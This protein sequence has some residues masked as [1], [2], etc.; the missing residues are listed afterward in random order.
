MKHLLLALIAAFLFSSAYGQDNERL[1]RITENEEID[2]FAKI[3]QIHQLLESQKK[4]VH[5]TIIVEYY[6]TLAQYAA[7]EQDFASALEYCDT[8]LKSYKN[9]DFALQIAVSERKASIYN[10]TGK[11]DRV[12]K[13]YM[14]I[15]SEQEKRKDY[16]EAAAVNGK[17]GV[18]FLKMDELES[19]EL[20]LKE[21]LRLAKQIG[22]KAMTATYLMSLGNRFKNEGKLDEAEKYYKECEKIAKE[23]NYKQTLAGNYN[24]Y[25]SLFRMRKQYA[26]AIKYFELAIKLN[27]ELG[28]DSW[29]SYNYNNIGNVY[30][31]QGLH[32]KALSYFFKSSDLKKS[33]ND[34]Y[35][36]YS[37]Y[38]NIASEYENLKDYQQA[39]KYFIQPLKIL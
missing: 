30:S 33:L 11:K 13:I 32:Q 28:N 19:A 39:Y 20:H 9:I 31:Y 4:K 2:N 21:A 15:L 10:E 7:L 26:Q 18:L 37:T 6:L 5:D 1:A 34:D 3:E 22:D 38:L 25:G 24:N 14:D 23:G 8:I 12:I 29:L 36:Q 17:L 16:R 27:I 35:G